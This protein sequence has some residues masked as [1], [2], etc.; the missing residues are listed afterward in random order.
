MN[1]D[2]I[3]AF[4]IGVHRGYISSQLLTVAALI[5]SPATAS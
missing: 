2:K 4:F 3:F 1:T 5:Q